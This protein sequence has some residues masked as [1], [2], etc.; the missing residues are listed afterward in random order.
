MMR[1]FMNTYIFAKTPRAMK[2]RNEERMPLA[3]FIDVIGAAFDQTY[4]MAM[5]N[6]F[7]VTNDERFERIIKGY[8]E[9]VHDYE[10]LDE[11]PYDRGSPSSS[12]K[13]DEIYP[14]PRKP[15]TPALTVK[16]AGFLAGIVIDSFR[17]RKQRVLTP[18]LLVQGEKRYKYLRV[19]PD[20]IK[21]FTV[22]FLL[23]LSL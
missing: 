17:F 9:T 4:R 5:E 2:I 3:L 8:L 22:T 13:Y 10:F 19:D 18:I 7:S 6:H 23:I 12:P 16:A 20:F 14:K 1:Y 21:D 11:N 15:L